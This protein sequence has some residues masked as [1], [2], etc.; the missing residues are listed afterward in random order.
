M[1]L[2]YWYFI[3][4]VPKLF[5][6]FCIDLQ[7]LL[8]KFETYCNISITSNNV[9]LSKH[10]EWFEYNIFPIYIIKPFSK[11]LPEMK[12]QL[13]ASNCKDLGVGGSKTTLPNIYIK[14]CITS[15]V[16]LVLTN[17]WYTNFKLVCNIITYFSGISCIWTVNI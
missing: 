9:K 5:A 4:Y 6:I 11:L 2:I 16:N 12:W 8:L 14:F 17:T 3:E 1:K 7:R 15:N 10:L 13:S